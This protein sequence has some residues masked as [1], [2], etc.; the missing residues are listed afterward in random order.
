[1][2]RLE[3]ISIQ[4]FKSFKRPATIP[5]PKNFSVIT[6]PNGSGKSNL[7]DAIFFVL[8]RGTSK[9]IRAKRAQD[10]IFQGSE[11]KEGSEYAKVS[12]VFSNDGKTLPVKEDMVTVTRKLNKEGVS[13]YRLNGRVLPRQQILDI[14]TQGRLYPGGH[15]II[16]QGDVTKVVEMNPLQRR[17]IIDEISGISE[18]DEK[19]L[20]SL[21]E[22]EKVE[23]KV[24]E[25]EIILGQKEEIIIRLKND[26]DAAMKYQG[27][28]KELDTI[29]AVI[30]YKEFTAAEKH[31]NMS[32][33]EIKGKEAEVEKLG[34]EIEALDK[35]MTAR[36]K[37]EQNLMS[38]VFQVSDQMKLSEKINRLG[39]EIEAK[40]NLIDLNEREVG[41][42]ESMIKNMTMIERKVSPGLKEIITFKGV[43]G[44]VSD[45]IIVPDKYKVAADVSGGGHMSDIV[46]DT[47]DVA[48]HCIKY[49]KEN[50]IGRGRFLPMDRIETPNKA[51][52]PNGSQGWMS[53]LIHH[54]P[55]YTGIVEFIFGR[56]AC[57][58]DIEKARDVAKKMRVRMVTLDG[59]LIETTGAM[60][61]GF[62]AKSGVAPETRRYMEEKERLKKLN[63]QLD[64]EI[65]G[66]TK[67]QNELKKGMKAFKS[68]DFEAKN[69]K[70]RAEIEKIRTKRRELY[71]LRL[72]LQQ[73]LNGI[74]IGK[75][76]LEAN[77]D[78]L[79]VKWEEGRKL[80]DACKDKEAYLKHGVSTL[81]DR[82][83]EIL[84]M[85][86]S[87]GPVNMKAIQ[88]FDVLKEEF[89]EFRARVD[90]IIHEKESILKSIN[91][92]EERKREVFNKTMTEMAR[93]FR[94]IY[95]DLSG[96]EAELT[97][98]SPQDL[99]TGLLISASPPGKKLL[100]IDSMSGGEKTITALAFLFTIQRYK[101][102]PFYVM[103]EIDAALDKPNTKKVAELI[104]KHSKSLQFIVITHNNDM[105]KMADQVFG[106]SMDEGES[107]IMGIDLPDIDKALAAGVGPVAA[108]LGK[109]QA[110]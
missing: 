107:K 39:T 82:E 26:R 92:I 57:M 32:D 108:A 40:D 88:D 13:T 38:Q 59:D 31:L 77:Y 29:T 69:K 54:E 53:E 109:H 6:G 7:N 10:L 80:F 50:R 42:L 100:Y 36:E 85:I 110:G 37:E 66:L 21:K 19:K 65:A 1:M 97:L 91:D 63:Q 47:M 12:L 84:M 41:R 22:L 61:G 8:G 96:G 105:I 52:L 62:Y 28:V 95:A 73:E 15:N 89:D 30:V 94:E 86:N 76:K 51:T 16:Q 60:T 34:K 5:F 71:D 102:A 18:Y 58:T 44:F 78:T 99:N 81:R 14:F 45:L 17:Q 104:R 103:D 72:N 70:I 46:V 93:L 90:R 49:L 35:E 43:H 101:P 3:K 2:V 75:A 4:G 27:M 11:K 87:S 83:K 79:K 64:Y 98:E 33:A 106:I 23:E 55:A 68:E 48:T 74:K 67:Q 9:G 56:T 25:A 20:Q 24:K